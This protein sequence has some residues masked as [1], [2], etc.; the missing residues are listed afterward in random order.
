M[1]QGP[2][3]V[4][5]APEAGIDLLDW[6]AS[7]QPEVEELL[8]SCGV[9]GGRL[10]AAMA[11]AHAGAVAAAAAARARAPGMRE[12]AEWALTTAALVQ[13]GK[14]LA[15][16]LWRG[17][18]QAYAAQHTASAAAEARGQ[19]AF[20]QLC[21]RLDLRVPSGAAAA[22]EV[23]GPGDLMDLDGPEGGLEGDAGP[24]EQEGQLAL[25]LPGVG[26]WPHGLARPAQWPRFLSLADA[27]AS[28]Q[29][30]VARDAAVLSTLLAEAAA[31]EAAAWGVAAGVAGLCRLQQL[32]PAQLA[33]LPAPLLARQ[34]QGSCST[35]GGGGWDRL[36]AS[37]RTVSLVPHMASA[38]AGCFAEGAAAAD[39]QLR[40]G[41][42]AGQL[43][44]LQAFG[45]LLG[46]SSSSAGGGA[47]VAGAAALA[48]LCQQQLSLLIQ[49]P[50]VQQLLQR[51]SSHSQ[52][53]TSTSAGG[54]GDA[55]SGGRSH[56]RR[57]VAA[58]KAAAAHA[59]AAEAAQEAAAAAVQLGTATPYQQSFWR[60]SR[61][62]ERAKR[63]PSHLAVEGL[64]PCL[65]CGA[66][67]E[68]LALQQL[69][70]AASSSSSGGCPAAAAA[71]AA[72]GAL[73]RWQ[74]ARWEVWGVSHGL[75]HAQ[76]L[77]QVLAQLPGSCGAAGGAAG[78]AAPTELD[79]ERLAW[80][81]RQ[82][83]KR[84]A[85]LLAAAPEVAASEAG[86]RCGAARRGD[87]AQRGHAQLE[88]GQVAG[89]GST[90]T[91]QA[92]QHVSSRQGTQREP[93]IR[94]GPPCCGMRCR[95]L[96]LASDMRSALGMACQPDR[97][98]LWRHGGHPQLPAS[99]E[100][101]AAQTQARAP[102][103]PAVAELPG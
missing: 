49:D 5:P 52:A 23:T 93:G 87:M 94:W 12:A 54:G 65:T 47:A 102:R 43:H 30:A 92:A 45:Q 34:L 64:H 95:W 9:A 39:W 74:A 40:L 88:R 29:G 89:L 78:A 80:A 19:A 7:G 50:S 22:D 20:L 86:Q 44:A 68:A 98:L 17:W 53:S 70:A 13:R 79:P 91:A 18:C 31:A 81:W 35:G 36:A 24:Q 84:T 103:P 14:G 77:G 46:L 72:T 28:R 6:A 48:R 66:Q 38:A 100:L 75:L 15:G 71:A 32:P 82:L 21:G 59:A 25:A 42:L 37:G 33:L 55:G 10:L 85:Q 51:L 69:C 41:W 96:L 83:D 76:M 90:H 11:A 60:S 26:G 4:N 97:P 27:A 61:P 73:E 101:A 63:A 8:S 62:Q 56:A 67:V 2:T 16:A 57:M 58:A 1:L 3:H 99:Q